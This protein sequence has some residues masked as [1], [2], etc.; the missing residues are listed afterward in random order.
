MRRAPLDV[1]AGRA[2]TAEEFSLAF[3]I[4]RRSRLVKDL[5]PHLDALTGRRRHLS[6]QGL[7]VA[8]Q[9]NALQRRHQAHLINAARMLNSLTC[10]QLEALGVYRWDPSHAYRRVQRLY[11]QLCALLDSGAAGIDA[12]T[13]AN[14][15]A[16]A[17][18]PRRYRLSR[19]VAVDG[20]DIETWGA[21]QGSVETLDLDGEA[22]S[23]DPD[24]VPQ[25]RAAVKAKR[26]RRAKVLA[27]GPDGRNQYTPD[28]DARAGH[29]SANGTNPAGPYL[30]YE[31]HL[32]VQTRD[33]RWTNYSNK[34]T[35]GPEVPNVITTLALRPAGSH[36]SKSIVPGLLAAKAAGQNIAEVLWD[37]GYSLN[38]PET[39]S[40]PL[41]QAGIETTFQPAAHQRGISPFSPHALVVD[42]QLYSNH[43]P[44]A[45]RDL[46]MPPIRAVGNYRRAYEQGFN[47]RARWRLVRHQRP[48]TDG[49]T[50]WK[51]PFCAGLLRSRAF[52]KTMRRPDTTPLVFLPDGT[53]RCCAGTVSAPPADLPLTQPIPF[54]TTAWR[55]SMNRRMA[56]ES[57]NASLKGGYVNTARG[58][59][60]LFGITKIT[61]LFGFTVAAV[62]LDRIRSH[63]AKQDHDSERPRRRQPRRVGT[64]QH[65]LAAI[66]EPEPQDNSPPG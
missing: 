24:P 4:V 58:F 37:P 9:L 10:D 56:V 25:N 7:L 30:G 41:R 61:V 47:Q 39:S 38:S 19:A 1:T 31:L 16:H 43:L 66:N 23:D 45:L 64:W 55:T 17:A 54:G 57:V 65:L 21:F 34:T 8:L 35:L 13:F 49:V 51:C 12:D 46:A 52:P 27:V 11:G 5:S 20:T 59:F 33:L 28:R 62:N 6:V 32:A 14:R 63:Q 40:H 50:R 29:R 18:I 26:N 2:P 48:D 36:R 15:L 42:G 3:D 22:T 44:I 53:T 60:R